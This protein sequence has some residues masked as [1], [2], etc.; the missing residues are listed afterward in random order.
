MTYCHHDS[1]SIFWRPFE[2]PWSFFF[3]SLIHL[4]DDSNTLLASRTH[5]R[6]LCVSPRHEQRRLQATFAVNKETCRRYGLFRMSFTDRMVGNSYRGGFEIR[7]LT[8][9]N[10]NNN[11][12]G[13][14][15][16]KLFLGTPVYMGY[17]PHI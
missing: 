15:S 7:G 3:T 9:N 12:L 4:F 16:I 8:I 14:S 6:G 10:S 5:S 11:N 13:N 17:L 2:L 1:I